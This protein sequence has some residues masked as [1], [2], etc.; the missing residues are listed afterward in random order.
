MSSRL[1]G[2]SSHPQG[3]AVSPGKRA[4]ALRSKTPQ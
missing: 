3:Y 2:K 4:V 1:A